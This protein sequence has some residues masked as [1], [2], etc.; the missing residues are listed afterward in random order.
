MLLVAEEKP[1][2]SG[3]EGEGPN[4]GTRGCQGLLLR[5][6]TLT[7]MVDFM[8]PTVGR[9]VRVVASNQGSVCSIIVL[10]H[11]SKLHRVCRNGGYG[12]L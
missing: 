2:D 3:S 12:G 7:F 6:C 9:I 5:E 8:Y 10:R 4:E 11:L 1:A